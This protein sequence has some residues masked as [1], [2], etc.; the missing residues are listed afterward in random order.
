MAIAALPLAQAARQREAATI[1][2]RHQVLEQAAR[3]QEAVKAA[4]ASELAHLLPGHLMVTPV[5]HL[6]VTAKVKR[7]DGK[8][9][10]LRDM[11]KT[12]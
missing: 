8:V 11:T 5:R 10:N 2:S 9:A 3:A 6:P 4:Q 1:V 12:N 7:L